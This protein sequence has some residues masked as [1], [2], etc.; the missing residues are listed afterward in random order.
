MKTSPRFFTI[1]S[2]EWLPVSGQGHNI[3]GEK[4]VARLMINGRLAGTVGTNENGAF[5]ATRNFTETASRHVGRYP[6][7]AEAKACCEGAFKGEMPSMWPCKRCEAPETRDHLSNGDDLRDRQLCHGCGFWEDWIKTRGPL[8]FIANG[9]AYE[10]GPARSPSTPSECL[11]FGG[12]RWIIRFNGGAFGVHLGEE[13]TNN[14]WCQGNVPEHFRAELPDSATLTA[15]NV[16]YE[17][18]Q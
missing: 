9:K 12:A 3:F 8:N 17:V 14:L 18:R 5:S 6:T 11:G 1:T 10:I 7:E 16:R 13:R 4:P 2:T 15:D